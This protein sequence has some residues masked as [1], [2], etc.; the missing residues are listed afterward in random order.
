MFRKKRFKKP[1]IKWSSIYVSFLM[2]FNILFVSTPFTMTVKAAVI[3]LA[4]VGTAT[5]S[6]NKNSYTASYANDKDLN[7]M[8]Q[9]KGNDSTRR[10]TI[11]LGEKYDLSGTEVVFQSNAVM[12]YT[13]DLSV[14]NSNWTLNVVNKTNNSTSNQTYTDNFSYSGIRYVRINITGYPTGVTPGIYEFRVFGQSVETPTFT[15]ASGSF[16]T[17]Q[18]V[19]IACTTPDAQIF[20]TTDGS[21]PTSSSQV[22]SGA[23]SVTYTTTIK[24]M[25]VKSGYSNSAVVSN[26][27]TITKVSAP[28]I[29]PA[30]GMFTSNQSVTLSCTTPSATIKYTTDGTTPTSNSTTYSAPIN[31]TST[32][33]IN[34]IAIKS[35]LTTSD[36]TS[37]VF[38]LATKAAAPTFS[39]VGGTYNSP[40][41]I[42]LSSA[43]SNAIIKYTIDGST[44]TSSSSTYN[45]PINVSSNT[46]VKAIA[47]KTGMVDSDVTTAVYSIKVSTPVIAPAAGSYNSP[48]SVSLS[49]S[50]T[51]ATIYYTTDGSTPTSSSTVYSSTINVGSNMTVK[52][53]AMKNNMTDSDLASAS[54]TIKAASPVISP[55]SGTYNSSQTVTLSST[56]DGAKIYYTT[57]GTTPTSGSTLYSAPI[58]VSSSA[59]VKAIAVKNAM[60]NSDVASA[61]YTIKAAA[62]TFSQVPGTYSC[63]Q[64]IILTSQSPGATIKYTT[65][66]STPTSTSATYSSPIFLSSTT[67]IKAYAIKSGITDSDI[68]SATYTISQSSQSN[69]FRVLEVEPGFSFDFSANTFKSNDFDGRPI[70]LDQMSMDEFISKIDVI[71]GFYDIVYIG[72]NKNDGIYS[73]AGALSSKLP[74]STGTTEYYSENDITGKRAGDLKDYINGKQCLLFNSTLFTDSSLSTTKLYSNFNS[75]IN[76][77]SY[78]VKTLSSIDYNTILQYYKNSAKRPQ[79]TLNISPQRYD[80][81]DASYETNRLINFNF[82][83]NN[84]NGSSNAMTAKLFLDSNGDGLFKEDPSRTIN[85]QSSGTGY[86]FDY[87]IPDSFSGLMPWKLEVTDSVTLAKSYITGNTAFKG[88]GLSV[89]VL[90]LSPNDTASFDLTRD[91][92]VSTRQAG[93]YTIYITKMTIQNFN[94]AYQNSL[95]NPTPQSAIVL[96]YDANNN[97]TRNTVSGV[98]TVLNGNYDMIVMGFIDMYWTNDLNNNAIQAIKDFIS[99]GQSAMFTHDIMNYKTD[100]T[101]TTYNFRD[102]IGQSRYKDSK[103]PSEKNLD[104][105]LI[106]HVQAPNNVTSNGYTNTALDRANTG[107][108]LTYNATTK[109]NDGVITQFPFSLGDIA[110]ATTHYQYYQL[111]LEDENVIPWY[112]LNTGNSNKYDGRNYYYTYSKGNIT[113]SG[114]GH[115]NPTSSSDSNEN[116]LFVNTMLKAART[117]NHAPILTLYGIEEGQYISKANPSLDFS[118]IA[119]DIDND[120]LKGEIYVNGTLIPG[121]TKTDVKSGTSVSVSISK[122]ILDALNTSNIKIGVKVTDPK[123]AQAYKEVN[124]IYANTPSLD[125]TADKNA[126]TSLVGDNV[127]ITLNA[128]ATN[129]DNLITNNTNNLL[130][131]DPSK[132]T[133]AVTG[134]SLNYQINAVNGISIGNVTFN[135]NPTP[136]V[137]TNIFNFKATDP[138]VFT[139][140]NQL[141][142][143]VNISNSTISKS[144]VYSYPITVLSSSI[145]V[146]IYNEDNLNKA[147]TTPATVKITKDTVTNTITTSTGIASITNKPSGTYTIEVSATGYSPSNYTTTVT[148]SPDNPNPDVIVKLHARKPD[149]PIISASTSLPTNQPI[150]VTVVY[151]EAL[152]NIPVKEISLDGGNTWSPYTAPVNVDRNTTIAARCAS[153]LGLYSEYAYYTIS[154]FDNTP[155]TGTISYKMVVSSNN[156]QDYEKDSTPLTRFD[157]KATVNMND[158]YS[159]S[160]KITLISDPDK[161]DS[162]LYPQGTYTMN[163]CTFTFNVD[164][165]AHD[166]YRSFT[167]YFKDEA[168]NIG[169]A[170]AVIGKID[171]VPPTAE[172]VY[173]KQVGGSVLVTLKQTNADALQDPLIMDNDKTNHVL[174]SNPNTTTTGTFY[175]HDAAG[176]T[177]YTN[178]SVEIGKNER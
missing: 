7:T 143:N 135:P 114:T 145:N 59:T 25:A 158:N 57:D 46:T 83:V 58:T 62:P 100:Y 86:S 101:N 104:G 27:Y 112:T 34:A 176:N 52:A 99:T 47:T 18:S 91:L 24:A 94:D 168:G 151:P 122:A 15:S 32:K 90:Q 51:E 74:A 69:E 88:D 79:I 22:Y 113:Y 134:P 175:F 136:A 54:Y 165:T 85:L 20:Y 44:P 159:S 93:K 174:I 23:I 105:T 118:Y 1:F 17:S 152:V 177:G 6:S 33:T 10:L 127:S 21:T 60:N 45:T 77:P 30:G 16:S 160:D 75:Y 115:S 142:Y 87:R 63:A 28:T 42:A 98:T 3:N 102:L 109:L 66:G 147:I 82:D 149:T 95:T 76:N 108:Y 89:R 125:L 146:K 124:L 153:D 138:G 119:D 70:K 78:N 35:G 148:L 4:S 65:D 128:V 137:Q 103:N 172:A 126:Y 164:N 41:A 56:T 169:R 133:S 171:K 31:I 157:I 121:L 55:T 132:L 40:Q 84:G 117:A 144:S 156:F 140:R 120:I 8:W 161:P 72:N 110:V 29:S 53:I 81:T 116:R 36:V 166:D 107:N 71:N 139:V 12:K 141:N 178:Y 123:K 43:T 154:N 131:T 150:T 162:N 167:F 92:S 38:T 61:A 106:P 67:V 130:T 96:G 5:A 26:T 11:D 163:N 111:N 19:T 64:S 9:P 129:P 170:T 97:I 39:P 2:L 37:A 80:G 14:D 68:V 173:K 73:A 50:T 13:I 48:Q 49:C 155:P